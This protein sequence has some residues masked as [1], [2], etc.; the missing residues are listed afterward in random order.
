MP[1]NRNASMSAILLNLTA[2]MADDIVLTLLL[3]GVLG[4]NDFGL[5]VRFWLCTVA[6]VLPLSLHCVYVQSFRLTG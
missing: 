1:S 4:S 3:C 2:C 6:W 5:C